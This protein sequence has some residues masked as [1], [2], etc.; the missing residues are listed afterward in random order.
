MLHID[1]TLHPTH[2]LI[3][4]SHLQPILSDHCEHVSSRALFSSAI[5]TALADAASMHQWPSPDA[6]HS[7]LMCRHCGFLLVARLPATKSHHV[8]MWH[9]PCQYFGNTLESKVWILMVTCQACLQG[10]VPLT[11]LSNADYT[12]TVDDHVAEEIG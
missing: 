11:L 8:V 4:L 6:A 1:F 10:S 12:L 7:F 3:L 2:T 5:E 9:A